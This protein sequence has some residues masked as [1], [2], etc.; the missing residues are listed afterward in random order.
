MREQNRVPSLVSKSQPYPPYARHLA[1]V[2]GDAYV[3]IGLLFNKGSFRAWDFR[4]S[5]QKQ[6][7]VRPVDI[8]AAPR[9]Y[10]GAAMASAGV[11]RLFLDLRLAPDGA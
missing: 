4:D 10:F 7:S 9:G 3:V 5:S 6:L 11:P 8:G 1:T 2:F